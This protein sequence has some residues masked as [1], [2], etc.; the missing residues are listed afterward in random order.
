MTRAAARTRLAAGALIARAEA[1]LRPVTD[2]ARLEA[3]LLLAQATGLA[4]AAIIAGPER[5]I[6]ADAAS[7]F[8]VLVA[9]R[10]RGE[11]LAYIVGYREF[12]SLGLAVG[13]AVLVPRPETEALVDA[14][15]DRLAKLGAK[16]LDLGTGS[17]AIALALK[18]ER[19]DLAVT[20]VDCDAAALEIAR[21]NARALGL[22]I[23]C[24]RSD[25]YAA[26][27]GER[28]DL[29]V[30]NPPYVA[31]GD[32]HFEGALA[33]EPR[34]A[35][36]GGGD[37]LKA[38]RAILRDAHLHLAPGGRLLVEHGFE[39]R[40]ALTRLASASGLTLDAAIDDLAG[41]PRVASFR[42]SVP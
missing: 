29:V 34:I 42:A 5:T 17:G 6:G 39:Q 18:H 25:W 7:R 19:R 38:H 20:A 41:L 21:A 40:E 36:D 11:P 37:G 27:A 2:T 28:F 13:P 24:L 4:R 8:E 23:R 12:Y 26:L 33:H 30:S 14:A 16:V 32:P 15:L 1:E 22:E 35:L 3:E 10:S 9:R 31:S